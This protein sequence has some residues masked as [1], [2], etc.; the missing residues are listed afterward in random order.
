MGLSMAEREAVSKQV[1]VRYRKAAK[2]D[3][4]VILTEHCAVTGWH[5][6]MPGGRCAATLDRR[7][8]LPGP[9]L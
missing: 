3:K 6:T 9:Q 5:G 8:T 7:P 2:K 1:A 4:A